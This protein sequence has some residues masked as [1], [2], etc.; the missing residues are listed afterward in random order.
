[1]CLGKKVFDLFSVGKMENRQTV[2]KKTVKARLKR[3]KTQAVAAVILVLGKHP[4]EPIVSQ[5]KVLLGVLKCPGDVAMSMR[6]KE[7]D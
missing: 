4:S 2:N 7:G 1:M 6:K 5:L 3:T